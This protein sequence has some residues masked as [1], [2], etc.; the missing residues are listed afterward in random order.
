MK[1][2]VFP[3]TVNQVFPPTIPS[4]LEVPSWVPEPIAQFARAALAADVHEVYATAIR[5]TE[6]C[7]EDE[8]R[9]LAECKETRVSYADMV[10]EDLAKIAERYRALT[11]DRQMRG[12]WRELSRLRRNG[13][14]LYPA[15]GVSQQAA[16]LEIFK[17]A[18]ECRDH[19]R[20]IPPTRVEAKQMHHR[21]LAKANELKSDAITV[22]IQHLDGLTY[23]KRWKLWATLEAAAEACE[24][25]A[26]AIRRAQRALPERERD[27]RARAVVRTISDKFRALFGSPMYGLTAIIT[28]VVL[29]RRI[30]PRRVRHLCPPCL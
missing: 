15:Q 12:V 13:C 27:A 19:L 11:C 30:D 5:E 9:A 26:N 21:Y 16:M 20:D 25:Y 4:E 7:D 23:E 8:A 3:P 6:D 17:T 29:N 22:V 1:A 28:S 24:Q 2:D 10:C 14:P 18:L